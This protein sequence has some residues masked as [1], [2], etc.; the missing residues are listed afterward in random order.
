[1]SHSGLLQGAESVVGAVDES[2]D[3]PLHLAAK[4]GHIDCVTWLLQVPSTTAY[5][6]M[7]ADDWLWCMQQ[8]ADANSSNRFGDT[9]MHAA[10]EANQMDVCMVT[11]ILQ[12]LSQLIDPSVPF[13]QVLLRAGAD[14]E[15]ANSIGI[16]P[17]QI[18]HGDDEVERQHLL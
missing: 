12:A 16:T 6:R 13:C 11:S 14:G 18:L 5:A 7:S 17:N 1:M 8:G 4:R 15:R 10:A 3:R 9:A 2:G